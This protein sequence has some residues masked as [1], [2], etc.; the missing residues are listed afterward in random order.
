MNSNDNRQLTVTPR[1]QQ[2]TKL[3]SDRDKAAAI[4]R[5]QIDR[6]YD[7]PQPQT[8]TQT[9]VADDNPYEQ[10]HDAGHEATATQWQH[11]HSAW[12][13]YYQQ[14]YER[15]YLAEHTKLA[16]TQIA[17]ASLA[18]STQSATAPEIMTEEKAVDEIRSDLRS[19]I[20]H[21]AKNVRKSRHF[22]PVISALVV[23]SL[24]LFLQY[25]RLFIGQLKSWVSPGSIAAQNIIIDPT[26]STVVGP[27]PK[28]VQSKMHSEAASFIIRYPARARIRAKRATRYFWATRQTTYSTM[29]TINSSSSSSNSSPKVTHF[30]LTT[31][32]Y[33]TPTQ[34]QVLKQSC[35]TKSQNLYCP[36]I[37]RQLRL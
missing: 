12:Q 29:A 32:R 5:D 34:S 2:Q 15:Y 8:V 14:Y 22:I 21:H 30:I 13:Q 11:Y 27:E 18:R 23:M 36:R 7:G 17:Q 10:T 3:A 33:A 24:F 16:Q 31:T 25:N 37:S 4:M 20:E 9:P 28:I 26:T 1:D 19:K 6:L 35:Q